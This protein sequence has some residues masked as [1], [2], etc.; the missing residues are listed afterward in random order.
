[1]PDGPSSALPPAR[2]HLYWLDWLRF[3]AAFTVLADHARAYNWTKLVAVAE[4]SPA[5]VV[6][7]W[8]FSLGRQAVVLFF[9]LSGWLVGG[10]AA[11]RVRAGTFDAMGYA[12]DRLARVYVPLLP[13][14]LFTAAVV[15]AFDGPVN[16]WQYLICLVGLQDVSG[17]PKPSANGPLWTLGYEIWFYVLAGCAAVACQRGRA[18][19]VRLVGIV[20]GAL[21]LAVCVGLGWVYLA[22][23]LA[24][25]AGSWLR[26]RLTPAVRPWTAAAGVLFMAVGSEIYLVDERIVPA[27]YAGIPW[28]SW[29]W[30]QLVVAAGALLLVASVAAMAPRTRGG[31]WIE[32]TGGVLAAFSYTLYLT[33]FPVMGALRFALG[34]LPP[35]VLDG[36]AFLRMVDGAALALVLALAMYVLFE[37]QTPRVRRWLRTHLGGGT[38]P[39]PAPETRRSKSPV[40]AY[41]RA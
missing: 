21:A 17:I 41:Q 22:C 12:A 14:L 36:P 28:P 24:G 7:I 23:W 9:V 25:A 3:L 29:E 38:V 31:R 2:Q 32:R 33:H 30:A 6:F 26:H 39:R 18:P 40:G 5:F 27:P 13:A 34:P 37:R 35:Q 16:P 8:L 1:M 19:W 15:R 10:H 11:A 20:G 4:D